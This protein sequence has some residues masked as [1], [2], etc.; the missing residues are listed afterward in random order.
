MSNLRRH[1]R[2]KGISC[3]LLNDCAASSIAASVKR[4]DSANSPIKINWT[5]CHDWSTT[6]TTTTSSAIDPTVSEY[7]PSS[8]EIKEEIEECDAQLKREALNIINY[9]ISCDPKRYIGIL[10]D[11]LWILDQFILK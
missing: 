4:V 11:W 9:F 2:S 10:M 3:E 1:F 7:H 5:A 6:V 8:G